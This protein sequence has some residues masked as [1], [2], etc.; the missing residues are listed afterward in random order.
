[1]ATIEGRKKVGHRPEGESR[2][3]KC[4]CIGLPCA[5]HESECL[6]V[7]FCIGLSCADHAAC[8]WLNLNS[9]VSVSYITF[10]CRVICARV[11]KRV[12]LDS[13]CN[14][15]SIPSILRAYFNF[16]SYLA[17]KVCLSVAVNMLKWNY[18]VNEYSWVLRAERHG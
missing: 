15:Y 9:S 14:L 10:D 2:K 4:F 5:D 12:N 11:S 7:C 8:I 1:M 13:S 18:M 17:P 3:I 16:G 6:L